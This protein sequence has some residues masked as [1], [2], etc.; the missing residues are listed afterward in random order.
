[1]GIGSQSAFF[2]GQVEK[3]P[4]A[5]RTIGGD[6]V[7]VYRDRPAHKLAQVVPIEVT[8]ILKFPQ[9]A[10]GIETVPRLSELEHDKPAH[11]RLIERSCCEHPEV[12]DITRLAALIAGANLF[13]EDFRKAE[14]DDLGRCERQMAE[15]ALFNLRAPFDGQR[16]RFAAADLCLISLP[17]AFQSWR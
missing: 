10:L 6:S 14:T 2:F 16:W 17:A 9:Q 4:E 15:V 8:A 1:M 13:G 7:L 12:V 5:A 11:E 3:K